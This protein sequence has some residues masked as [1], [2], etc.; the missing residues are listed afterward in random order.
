ML[1]P[2]DICYGETR[3]RFLILQVVVF[4]VSTVWL[5]LIFRQL[6]TYVLN[7]ALRLLLHTAAAELALFYLCDLVSCHYRHSLQACFVEK[8]PV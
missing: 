4:R 7:V 2:Y 5:Y 6:V 1:E 8:P 3:R